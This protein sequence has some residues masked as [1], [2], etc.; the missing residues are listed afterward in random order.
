MDIWFNPFPLPHSEQIFQVQ[1]G[2]NG[3]DALKWLIY[4]D[5]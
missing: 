3:C 2:I 5:I 1:S 4:T